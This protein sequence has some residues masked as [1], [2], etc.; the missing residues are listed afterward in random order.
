[1]LYNI[2]KTREP[3]YLNVC[4]YFVCAL[5]YNGMRRDKYAIISIIIIG[6][7]AVL[8]AVLFFHP[9]ISKKRPSAA[10]REDFTAASASKNTATPKGW[11][12]KSRPGTK[13]ALF[14]V[15]TVAE[16]NVTFLRMESDM[17]SAS[18]ITRVD[19]LDIKKTPVLQWRWRAAEL[20]KGADGRI[21]AKDDQA[22]AI[23]VGSGNILDN[24]SISYRWDT[25]TPKGARGECAYGLGTIK[26][27]WYT[28]RNEKDA[29]PGSWYIEKRNVAKDFK[30]AWGFYPK[31]VYVSVSCNSQYTASR[32]AADL[33]W[34][35]FLST[36]GK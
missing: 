24:K 35:E 9:A 2:G 11:K 20:P 6:C 12:I 34:I 23:Y 10:W 18:L 19:G 32:A 28:L 36:A 22:I 7:A 4:K 5:Q 14:F 31:T 30:K 3:H 21:R 17:A 29:A 25:L 33:D 26:I 1:M 15:K 13:P 16:E 27:K 8:A